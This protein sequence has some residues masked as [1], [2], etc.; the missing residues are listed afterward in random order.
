MAEHAHF[1]VDIEAS[2]PYPPAYSMIQIG[3]VLFEDQ[4]QTFNEFLAPISSNWD[5]GAEKVHGVTWERALRFRDPDRVMIQFHEWVSL[6]SQG[7]RAILVTD[8]PSFD[9]AFINF[10][11]F[12][13][14]GKNIFGHSSLPLFWLAK[15]FYKNS[16]HNVHQYR[17]VTHSH[18]ALQDAQGNAGIL[19]HL[20]EEGFDLYGRGQ[21]N[22]S[23]TEDDV[24]ATR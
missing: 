8:T 14:V 17:T 7:K 5:E 16:K 22:S 2:G 3:A 24:S 9:V 13:N 21:E 6:H 19:E 12:E 1:I 11:L 20:L 4:T 15:G 23:K 18:D 10:Y